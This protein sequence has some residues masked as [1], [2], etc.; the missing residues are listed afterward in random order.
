MAFSELSRK[1]RKISTSAV[2]MTADAKHAVW[3]ETDL[4]YCD[5]KLAENGRVPFCTCTLP[6]LTKF[7][8]NGLFGQTDLFGKM[9]FRPNGLL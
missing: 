4:I 9:G 3:D 6:F 2:K 7:R 8:P 1:I 5:I